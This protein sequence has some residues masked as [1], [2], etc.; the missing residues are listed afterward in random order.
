MFKIQ[1]NQKLLC[2]DDV[3]N[4]PVGT[5]KACLAEYG[6]ALP[7]RHLFDCLS[8]LL[9]FWCDVMARHRIQIDARVHH[10]LDTACSMSQF[11]LSQYSDQLDPMAADVVQQFQREAQ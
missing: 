4:D 1:E 2:W 10:P 7:M 8:A 9:G 6:E 3:K 11:H 5:F